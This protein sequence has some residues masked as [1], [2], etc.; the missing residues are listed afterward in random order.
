MV[1]VLPLYEGGIGSSVEV[2]GLWLE[3]PTGWLEGGKAECRCFH[4]DLYIGL[5]GAAPDDV[6]P[7][8]TSALKGMFSSALKMFLAWRQQSNWSTRALCQR[9][10]FFINYKLHESHKLVEFVNERSMIS[11]AQ[12]LNMFLIKCTVLFESKFILGVWM[13]YSQEGLR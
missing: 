2:S 10:R 1:L 4:A 8:H 9:L 12:A 3:A 5:V 6:H 13:L 11:D 7:S